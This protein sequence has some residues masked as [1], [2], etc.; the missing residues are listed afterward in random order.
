MSHDSRDSKGWSQIWRATRGA[1]IGKL[2]NVEMPSLYHLY[3]PEWD[4]DLAVKSIFH[5]EQFPFGK[6]N[7]SGG[8]KHCGNASNAGKK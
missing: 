4:I 7:I 8:W 6:P 3:R 5:P 2:L 1:R